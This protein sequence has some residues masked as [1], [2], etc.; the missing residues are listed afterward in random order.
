M[1]PKVP[2]TRDQ[3]STRRRPKARLTTGAGAA[4]VGRGGPA[5]RFLPR[6]CSAAG[7]TR[8]MTAGPLRSTPEKRLSDYDDLLP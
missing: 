4:G 8:A 7:C 3:S 1:S 6:A 5:G 2:P